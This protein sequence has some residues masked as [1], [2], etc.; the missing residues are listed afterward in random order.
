MI[1][2][3]LLLFPSGHATTFAQHQTFLVQLDP[4]R[5]VSEWRPRLE[6]L[7]ALD[8]GHW[9]TYSART[10]APG[11]GLTRDVLPALSEAIATTAKNRRTHFD[12]VIVGHGSPV[13]VGRQSTHHERVDT[14]VPALA[15]ALAK[16]ELGTSVR[17]FLDFCCAGAFWTEFRNA[18]AEL[19]IDVR[20]VIATSGRG[21]TRGRNF[22][23][24][25][26]QSIAILEALHQTGLTPATE[27]DDLF[28]TVT[29]LI[30]AYAEESHDDDLMRA[31]AHDPAGPRQGRD[32]HPRA[33][34]VVRPQRVRSQLRSTDP[35]HRGPRRTGPRGGGHQPAQRTATPGT[36][37]DQR[38]FGRVE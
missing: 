1:I 8:P 17:I 31:P 35:L 5:P 12:L 25:L 24:S 6:R 28:Q 11:D 38:G 4:H 9:W 23:R 20:G 2:F 22:Q 16:A 10:F 15:R 29:N 37:E 26:D 32:R 34:Q 21:K 18:A 13:V 14:V 33:G 30:G 19:P 7:M 3:L 27:F 36:A